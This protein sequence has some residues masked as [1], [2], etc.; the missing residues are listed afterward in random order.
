[1]AQPGTD[2]PAGEEVRAGTATGTAARHFGLRNR[3]KEAV[4]SHRLRWAA[5]AAA[6]LLVAGLGKLPVPRAWNGAMVCSPQGSG[7]Q[8]RRR[9]QAYAGRMPFPRPDWF[10]CRSDD[11]LGQPALLRRCGK[12]HGAVLS[13]AEAE[14]SDR[15]ELYDHCIREGGVRVQLCDWCERCEWC[16]SPDHTTCATCADA[17]SNNSRSRGQTAPTIGLQCKATFAALPLRCERVYC[18]ECRD[19]ELLHSFTCDDCGLPHCGLCVRPHVTGTT[20]GVVCAVCERKRGAEGP[21][22]PEKKGAR[23][24]KERAAAGARAAAAMRELSSESLM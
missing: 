21:D 14:Q 10:A 23:E 5:G 22:M 12:R 15:A 19:E 4:I 7:L 17:A 13:Q 9:V 18:E 8:D 16:S 2:G 11:Q 24:R 20:G 1:M 6:L 3:Q